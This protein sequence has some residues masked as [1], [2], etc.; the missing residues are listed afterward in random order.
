MAEEEYRLKKPVIVRGKQERFDRKVLDMLVA[1]LDDENGTGKRELIRNREIAE[2]T[3]FYERWPDFPV[4]FLAGKVR[5]GT[6]VDLILKPEKSGVWHLMEEAGSNW[7]DDPHGVVFTLQEDAR[8]PPMVVLNTRAAWE[9][10][11]FIPWVIEIHLLSLAKTVPVMPFTGLLE[12][13]GRTWR[14]SP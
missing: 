9:L 14:I 12:A 4:R 5:Q 1:V 7:P 11:V 10:N 6:L 8:L 13:I 2:L 3:W